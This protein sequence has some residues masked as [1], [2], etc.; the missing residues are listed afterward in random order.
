[1]KIFEKAK[2]ILGPLFE[3][4]FSFKWR[5]I[6][7]SAD[8]FESLEHLNQ[9]IQEGG[10]HIPQM[11]VSYDYVLPASIS[12]NQALVYGQG[13]AFGYDWSFDQSFYFV[14]RIC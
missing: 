14:K 3:K 4:S 5:F 7:A 1:M 13:I 10:G 2:A 6:I 8:D 12:E 11:A 9:T